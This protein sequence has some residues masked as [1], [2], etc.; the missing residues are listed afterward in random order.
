MGVVL[1]HQ[2]EPTYS[3]F[4]WD[5]NKLGYLTYYIAGI[6]IVWLEEKDYLEQEDQ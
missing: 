4:T 1:G 5:S 2:P 3:Y 6:D